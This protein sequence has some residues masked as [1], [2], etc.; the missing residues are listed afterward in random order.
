MPVGGHARRRAG[1]PRELA[2]LEKAVRGE[3]GDRDTADFLERKIEKDELDHV[4][5]LHHYAVEGHETGIEQVERETVGDMVDLGICV[6]RTAIDHRGPLGVQPERRG[7]FLGERTLPPVPF[8]AVPPGELRRER[9][10]P[11]EHASSF[12]WNGWRR[13]MVS[14]RSA[15]VEIISIGT[16][17]TDCSL[18]RYSRARAG[19]FS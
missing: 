18:S 17:H 2:D 14:F 11:F 19:S 1:E 3:R 12:Q 4:G 5:Q 8:H 13:T 15:P 9:H 16:P 7:K 6:L 10:D